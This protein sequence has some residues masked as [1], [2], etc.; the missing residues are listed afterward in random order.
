MLHNNLQNLP[1]ALSFDDVLL[2]PKYTKIKSRSQVDL[3][4]QITPNIK[5]KIPLITTKMDTVTGVKM[6]IKIGE[7]GGMGMLPRFDKPEIHADN[8]KKVKEAGVFVGAAIGCKND[9]M[10]RAEMLVKA[11]VDA[12]HTDVAHGHLQMNLDAISAVKNKFGSKVDIIG[13]ICAT[14]ESAVAMYKAGA[15]MVS[16]GVGGGS[17]CT[18]RIMT[19]CGMPTFQTLLEVSKAAKEHNKT[20][21]PEAGIRNSGDIVKSLATGASAIMGGSIYAGTDEAPGEVVE[22]NGKMYKQYSGSTALM[23]KKNQVAKDATGKSGEYVKHIEGV[24]ALKPY[25]GS[26]EGVV[27]GLLAGVKSGFTYCNALNLQDLW[28]N[29]EFIRITNSGMAESKPHEVVVVENE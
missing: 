3:S 9:F 29:A 15:D 1:T 8:V 11:G 21:M 4:T 7:L 6:A 22:V 10:E 2:V 16:C 24:D 28:Q 12:L 5:L 17:I 20:F 23:Q 27:E 18:T 25:R 19:G 13:G 26:V 14:Y